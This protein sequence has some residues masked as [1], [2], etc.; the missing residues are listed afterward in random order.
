MAL[1]Q[2]LKT[3]LLTNVTG[4]R[5]VINFTRTIENLHSFVYVSS[6]Y[7]N[8][9]RSFIEE[10]IYPSN[11]EPQKILNLLEWMDE[12][13]L[14]LATKKLIGDKPNT[15]TYT[16]WVA[17]TLLEQEATDLPIAIVRPSIIGASWKEPFAGWVEKS[18]GPCDLFIA[19]KLNFNNT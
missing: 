18:S 2:D 13:W 1:D 5:N 6:V 17:E 12:D 4:L 9:N 8:C 3:A 11:T 7:A 10:Q 14:K 16:K 19:V 15:F